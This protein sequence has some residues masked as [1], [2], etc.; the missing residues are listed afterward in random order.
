MQTLY[1]TVDADGTAVV[2]MLVVQRW[3]RSSGGGDG[4][5]IM[6]YSGSNGGSK[7]TGYG[8]GVGSNEL[9]TG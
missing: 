4:G 7:F 5:R 9:I 6:E 1:G 3:P 2:V 8:G